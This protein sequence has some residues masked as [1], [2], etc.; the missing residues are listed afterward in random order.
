MPKQVKITPEVR[1]VLERGEWAGWLFKLNQ[2]GLDRPLYEAVNKVLVALGGKWN[3]SHGGHMF[4]LDAKP[5]MVA[6]LQSGLAIDQARTAE[7]FF[8]PPE[9]AQRV[10]AVARLAGGEHVL[11][12]SAGAGAL[13]AEPMRLG[14]FISA[15]ERDERL[16]DELAEAVHIGTG[17]H[18]S[19]VWKADF[20]E[21][22]PVARAPIDVVLMNPP[23]SRGQDMA[24]VLRAFSFLRPGGVLVS[25]MSSHWVFAKDRAANDFRA[26]LSRLGDEQY[27][28]EELPAG[29]F[30]RSGTGVNTGLLTMHKGN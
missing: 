12:P 21:W 27:D 25:V 20:M 23:F 16:A 29:S 8:T 1:A 7:Q 15:V 5:A 28:W 19:G 26:E 3:R 10:W 11:E 24:H 13:L 14:C 2:P 18:G 30:K 9:V 4:S 17:G 6:A 22:R